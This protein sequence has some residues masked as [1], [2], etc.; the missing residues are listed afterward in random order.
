MNNQKP[1]YCPT[2]FNLENYDFLK[3]VDTENLAHFFLCQTANF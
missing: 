1:S 3:T 2:W